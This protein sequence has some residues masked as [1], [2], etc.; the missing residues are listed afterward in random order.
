MN[1]TTN[2]VIITSLGV[3]MA[4][5]GTM[6]PVTSLP[7]YAEIVDAPEKGFSVT[8]LKT[9]SPIALNESNTTIK[10]YTDNSKTTEIEGV[11]SVE[12]NRIVF[13]SNQ[14]LDNG[15]EFYFS[16]KVEGYK[17][18]FE[19]P[20]YFVNEDVNVKIQKI[21][22]EYVTFKNTDDTVIAENE[23]T[24]EKDG[25]AIQVPFTNGAFDFSDYAAG[26]V[27]NYSINKT[28]YITTNG[29]IT[30]ENG[31]STISVSLEE[32]SNLDISISSIEK[33]YGDADFNISSS[34]TKPDGYTGIFAYVIKEGYDVV[35]IA[36]D[37][38]I[39]IKKAGTA[40]ITVRSEETA[41]NKVTETDVVVTVNKKDLGTINSSMFEWPETIRKTYDGKK[42]FSATGTLKDGYGLVGGDVISAKVEMDAAFASVGKHTT[43]ITNVKFDGDV[44]NYTY[45]FN[46]EYGPMV[47]ITAKEIGVSLNDYSVVYG[48]DEW[49]ALKEGTFLAN[50]DFKSL[51]SITDGANDADIEAIEALD[52][53]DIFL[54]MPD[55]QT[56]Q[57]GTAKDKITLSTKEVNVG[58][59]LLTVN[60]EK[61]DIIVS[62]QTL[63]DEEAWS[64]V[65]VDEENSNYI[66]KSGDTTFVRAGGK[67][68]FKANDKEELYDTVNVK[69]I[70]PNEAQDYANELNISEDAKSG[71]VRA[72]YYLSNSTGAETVIAPRELPEGFIKV[73]ADYPELTFEDGTGK[74][75][76]TKKGETPTLNTFTFD[77]KVREE[78]YTLKVAV[79]DSMS[80]V[81][82]V[83]YAI[84]SVANEDD[85]KNAITTAC[86][87]DTTIWSK[88]PENKEVKVDGKTSGYYIVLVK[89]ADKVGNEAV[90]ASNGTVVDVTAPTLVINGINSQK[91]YREDVSYTITIED[92]KDENNVH[93]G[94]ER[95]VV[96]VTNNDEKTEGNKGVDSYELT[97]EDIYGEG[98]N[99]STFAAFNK[100][101]EQVIL[102]GTITAKN[103]SSNNVK[104]EV[105]VYDKSGNH[106]TQEK[107]LMIDIDEPVLSASYD[108]NDV[109]NE[110]YFNND[111]KMTLSIT[112]RNFEEEKLVITASVDGKTGNYSIEQI[113]NKEVEGIYL[114]KDRVDSQENV[115][116]SAYTNERTNTYVIG[117]G[118]NGS[119]V[120]HDY[121]VNVTYADTKENV[122]TANFGNDKATTEFTVDKIAPVLSMTY[123]NG[124]G[125]ETLA[126]EDATNPYYDTKEVKV[127]VNIEERNFT[128]KTIGLAVTS[129]NSKGEVVDGYSQNDV[130]AAMTGNWTTEGN[131]HSYKMKTF[132]ND[133]NYSL[134]ATY[135]D[136]AGNKAKDYDAHYFTVD[137][138][139]PTGKIYMTGS[140]EQKKEYSK[141][142]DKENNIFIF[143][144]NLF[145]N[146]SIKAEYEANDTTSGLKSVKYCF[147]DALAESTHK[148]AARVDDF[149]QLEWKDWTKDLK[150]DSDKMAVLFVRLEDKAG[151]LTYI[152]SDG[153]FIVDKKEAEEPVLAVNGEKVDYHKENFV[154]NVTAQDP[155]NGGRGIFSGI[156]KISYQLFNEITGE[157]SEITELVNCENPRE[158]SAS[159]SILIDASKWNTNNL[160]V[161]V[162]AEDYAGNVVEKDETY[163]IDATAP[164]VSVSM[165]TSDVKNGKYYNTTKFITAKFNE[166]N[167]D[168][169]KAIM[170]VKVD[171]VE[172]TYS[173]AQL[174]NGDAVSEGIIV[175]NVSDT[176]ENISKY[177]LTDARDVTY[178]IAVGNETNA[179]H[180]YEDIS[181]ECVDLAENKGSKALGK[182]VV[183]D[184]IAPVFNIRYTS[185]GKDITNYVTT[186][187]NSPYFGNEDV[188]ATLFVDEKHFDEA[189]I[190]LSLSQKDNSGNDVSAYD[191]SLKPTGWSM[192][193]GK[194]VVNMKAFSGDAIYALAGEFVDL[195]GNKAEV[196]NSHYFC[197][198]KTA[199][200]GSVTINA[201]TGAIT[202]EKLHEKEQ[203]TVIEGN[204]VTISRDAF[205][206]VSGVASIKYYKYIPDSEARDTFE[207]LTKEELA[208][209]NWKNWTKDLSVEPDSQAV[210][211][212]RITDRAG[213]ITY[214]NSKG[215]VIADKTNPSAPKISID[216]KA[217]KG[218]FNKDIPVSFSVEDVLNGGTYAGLKSVN[219]QVLKDGEKTQ[220]KTYDYA[221]KEARQ[222]LMNASIVVDA[223]KNN[224]NNVVVRV[225]AVD[226]AGNQSS[227]EKTIAV[228]VTAPRIEVIYDNN[229]PQNDKYYNG[230]R[231]ATVKVYER[232]FDPEGIE[233]NIT[234]SG[235][236]KPTISGWTIG[237]DAGVSD[238]NVS[239]CTIT[240]SA[241]ADYT[242]TMSATD[243]AGNKTEYGKTDKFVI[244]RTK[245]VISVNFDANNGKGKYFNT[246]R[247]ATITVTEHNFDA[248]GFTSA[249]QA[250]LEGKGISSPSVSSWT[251]NGDKHTATIHFANDGDYSFVLDFVDL[252]GNK[253]DTYIQD[254]FT[255]DLVAPEISFS[256]VADK[257]ANRGDVIPVINLS[258]INFDKNSVSVT[259]EGKNHAKKNVTGASTIDKKGGTITLA[260]FKHVQ[261]EDDV[262]T[263]TA[264][265]TD[266]AG[267]T[268][269]KSI[270]FSVNRFGSNYYFSKN[271]KE[272]LD[273][274][275]H[276]VGE[277]IV[278]YETNVD[279]LKEHG[280]TLIHNG[281]AKK[282]SKDMYTVK[283]I[284]QEG[285]W[286]TYAYT[287]SKDCFE[288]EGLYEIVIDSVD[289]AG[290]RQDNKLKEA[291]IEFVID[292]TAPSVVI[293][294]VEN[295]AIYD[296]TSRKVT[297]KVSD[298]QA[299]GELVIYVDGKEA[300]KYN[301]KQLVEMDGIV[302]Y[303][304]QEAGKWQE[305]SAK[306]IDAAGNESKEDTIKILVTTNS[307][308]RMFNN[309]AV[310]VG[311]GIGVVAALGGFLLFFA[312]K[313]KKEEENEK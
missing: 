45:Q 148:I 5:S 183:V 2:K 56:Y 162:V 116:P 17:E 267:N 276:Q 144:F 213:N 284:S 265:V 175:S 182:D 23:I 250:Y 249:M 131:M 312:K 140:N 103:N 208:S 110:K 74:Y 7:V 171:G 205:D 65:A 272:F 122:F 38:M 62:A 173:M 156:K 43:S 189:G 12:G 270:T 137:K 97:A 258:D 230:V 41:Q 55:A 248:K 309:T 16:I 108:N 93:T 24:F 98:A 8:D 210:L 22:P 225:T 296:Q 247:T 68:V 278:I 181:F 294:G 206:E 199:P 229:D 124:N 47:E 304:V 195:A 31:N 79:K 192:V 261:S 78:G 216:A 81:D 60:K 94:I 293:T 231:T 172:R 27:I 63:T 252:A 136:L 69:E 297:F 13:A 242:F 138:T 308:L 155:D 1:K 217:E 132:D 180:I 14:A 204:S 219:V 130:D 209:L 243:L 174:V 53:A 191:G 220:E 289:K 184:K 254:E 170:K 262:Y 86:M 165:D 159:G 59:Y 75:S 292:K 113:R 83:E 42:S 273:A 307:I 133:A 214:V 227:S 100:S 303:E 118:G 239:T 188:V 203:F 279:E 201:Q 115:N 193:D 9:G 260:D 76:E 311:T 18:V 166:R 71:A 11:A 291:P 202:S 51:V 34:I 129:K 194:H 246:A 286:K 85:V 160:R 77:H 251:S 305:I 89:T 49:K 268:T 6:P 25:T 10:V 223:K 99:G 82:T 19:G 101:S 169:T 161:H 253:A 257:S 259:L 256:G 211:Y 70:S 120:D 44:E 95:V 163:V 143:I 271:S 187:A 222:Q 149:E 255:I 177:E 4:V 135:M 90:Y 35:E 212:A 3:M 58:N 295:N 178:K 185:G 263:L 228:D 102:N 28:G 142:T 111:R 237:K 92:P 235:N 46:Q 190:A 150:I 232:N 234:G 310:R 224:S 302:E 151:H 88:L 64:K 80:G 288:N 112:E 106:Y 104:I 67:V 121:I 226:Y 73:D 269:T 168:A 241:D 197:V 123:L 91:V 32:K 50:V 298:D 141:E 125:T 299:L 26:D 15:S 285:E 114:A 119:L 154:V 277:D 283:D 196:Y 117:F 87:N 186:N 164:V 287:I 245:P 36:A 233:M 306:V 280:V 153:A 266:A 301:A 96:N 215:A 147:L 105:T 39:A 127:K 207:V 313:K 57:V 126:G 20:F 157:K 66:F 264:T 146:N 300:I 21:T 54:V 128:P 29:S 48:S 198:D 179:D 240:Y 33:T 152:R 200:K 109:R 221:L 158:R 176:Q 275:Y 218:V 30:L 244:D 282:L 61:A 236:A 281:A 134:S 290:N 52:Y 40:V 274:R 107:T 145:D 72:L 84:I 238:D 37:G 139:A 167:F